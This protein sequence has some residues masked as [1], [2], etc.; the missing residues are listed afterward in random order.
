MFTIYIQITVYSCFITLNNSKNKLIGENVIYSDNR[1]KYFHSEIPNN[2]RIN[3]NDLHNNFSINVDSFFLYSKTVPIIKL[4]PLQCFRNYTND[5]SYLFSYVCFPFWAS[6]SCSFGASASF[7]H[8]LWLYR[9][10][11]IT[12][13]DLF[14][15]L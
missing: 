8:F 10:S 4:C 5:I 3:D 14:H 12:L 13:S 9:S 6:S 1:H 15:L 11:T 2:I 7:H